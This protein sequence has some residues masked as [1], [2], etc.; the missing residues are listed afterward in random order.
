[1]HPAAAHLH[2]QRPVTATDRQPLPAPQTAGRANRAS[3]YTTLTTQALQQHDLRQVSSPL[4]VGVEDRQVERSRRF[5]ASA[6]SPDVYLSILFH[7]QVGQV[8][9]S[10]LLMERFQASAIH[11]HHPDVYWVPVQAL[12]GAQI[13]SHSHQIDPHQAQA[14]QP[15]QVNGTAI[16]DFASR[17]YISYASSIVAKHDIRVTNGHLHALNN[18]TPSIDAVVFAS[19]HQYN[20]L[21]STYAA[22]VA[23][24]GSDLAGVGVQFESYPY[25]DHTTSSYI[26]GDVSLE[27]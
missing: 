25:W 26:D 1:M 15:Q 14:V 16:T 21:P 13:T 5:E 18:A 2:S 4:D 19:D 10:L 20:V 27:E 23:D 24:R 12:N 17:E 3:P 9:I 8:P 6:D 22:D 7:T 11:P